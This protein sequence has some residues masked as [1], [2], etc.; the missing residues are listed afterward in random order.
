[1]DRKN[2]DLFCSPR[3][4]TGSEF[5]GDPEQGIGPGCWPNAA[6]THPV[7]WLGE[8]DCLCIARVCR[9]LVQR[10]CGRAS[11]TNPPL[12]TG[13]LLPPL[14]NLGNWGH[15]IPL[16]AHLSKTPQFHSLNL[17]NSPTLQLPLFEAL[18]QNIHF[19]CLN[20][21]YYYLFSLIHILFPLPR[22]AR[23]APL[24][25][26]LAPTCRIA[27]FAGRMRLVKPQAAPRNSNSLGIQRSTLVFHARSPS[28][29]NTIKKK[30]R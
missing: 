6:I 17:E 29:M 21:G 10:G 1:M 27:V 28:V 22:R 26:R 5:G 4:G 8:I 14:K 15:V 24:N 12:Y 23:N 13:H 7:A 3:A 11:H 19:S 2:C 25:L 9:S 20:D 16:H 18:H 30:K